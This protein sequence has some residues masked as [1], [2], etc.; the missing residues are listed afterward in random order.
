[1][2]ARELIGKL[3]LLTEEQKEQPIFFWGADDLPVIV[4]DVEP[5]I[6]NDEDDEEY[7][8]GFKGI[9]LNENL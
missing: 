8:K 2:N 1:M 6:Y 5:R 4:D 3:I 7:I 9:E